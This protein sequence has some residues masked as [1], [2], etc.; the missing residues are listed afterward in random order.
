MVKSVHGSK[1]DKRLIPHVK[2]VMSKYDDNGDGQYS[3]GEF[4]NCHKD[5]PLLFMPASS[6]PAPSFSPQYLDNSC[7][8]SG[9]YVKKRHGGRFLW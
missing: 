6:L 4:K 1:F 8:F 2:K 9:I 7:I 5:L 3:F